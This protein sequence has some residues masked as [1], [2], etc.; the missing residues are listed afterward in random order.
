[1][2]LD[3]LSIDRD[4]ARRR[5]RARW[6][7]RGVPLLVLVG[8]AFVFGDRLRAVAAQVGAPEVSLAP[9]ERLDPRAVGALSG[10]AANGYVIAARR[11]ALSADTPG[12]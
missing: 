2:D 3:A 1:M 8:L 7:R 5:R 9:A 11:A 12:R 10:A 6:I 4:R